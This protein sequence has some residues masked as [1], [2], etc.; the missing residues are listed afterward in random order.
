MIFLAV[1][2]MVF[3]QYIGLAQ[4][5][6][7]A[8]I[9]KSNVAGQFYSANP[10]ILSKEVE[11]FLAKDLQAAADK[12]AAVLILPHAGYVYSGPV[13]AYGYKAVS[14][15]SYKTIII[16]GLSH[17]HRFEGFAIWPEGR[18]ETPLGSVEVDADFSKQIMQAA[19]EV[20]S[21]SEAFDKEHSLEVQLPF[22]QKIFRDFKI[23]PLLTGQPN[24]DNCEKLASVLANLIGHRE[25]ILLLISSDMSHYR[26]EET[27]RTMDKRALE[28]IQHLKAKEFWW[29]LT[30]SRR[31]KLRKSLTWHRGAARIS[32]S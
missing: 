22:L 32:A 17:H 12:K 29:M 21:I 18:F 11:D 6:E 3:T 13:A 4:A 24:F 10:E 15:Q 20:K 8:M 9:K 26:D 19:P 2:M 25:D 30:I 16:I 7:D 1:I 28:M 31:G 27:T 5:S 23:V 14:A